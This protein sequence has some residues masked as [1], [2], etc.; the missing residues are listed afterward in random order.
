MESLT[1]DNR[2]IFRNPPEKPQALRIT[3]NKP[4]LA[5]RHPVGVPPPQQTFGR[6]LIML[7][8]ATL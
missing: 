2:V 8:I 3:V 6:W 5:L 7:G 1:I 4:K